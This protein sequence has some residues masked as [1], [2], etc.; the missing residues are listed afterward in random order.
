MI[1]ADDWTDPAVRTPDA[2]LEYRYAGLSTP[3]PTL[4]ACTTQW[5]AN[6]RIV[7]NYETHIHPLWSLPRTD[8]LANDVTCSQGG[9]HAPVDAMGAPFVPAGQLDLTDGISMDEA[10]HFNAYRELLFNTDELEL[11]NNQLVVVQVQVDV[12]VDGNPIF[13]DAQV[14][15]PMRA[16]GANASGEFFSVFATGDIHEGYLTPD[17]LRL[18][19]EWLD[20]GAQYYNN[21]FDVPVM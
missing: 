13:D 6:C 1:Y 9:C 20:V 18:L 4:L 19:A 7:I 12:D 5:S 14:A 3:L 17:E 10:D 8:A 21:P 16:A 11:V 15:G 2:P